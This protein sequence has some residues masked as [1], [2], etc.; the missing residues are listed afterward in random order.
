M[1]AT[2]AKLY[3]GTDSSTHEETPL[4]AAENYVLYYNAGGVFFKIPHTEGTLNCG[5]TVT[6]AT[7]IHFN[8]STE[9]Y[10]DYSGTGTF[11]LIENE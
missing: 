6:S 5:L 8:N 2:S 9:K 7:T 4:H 1:T 3:V 11:T 10:G